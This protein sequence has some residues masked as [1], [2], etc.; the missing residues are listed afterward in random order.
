MMINKRLIG[1]VPD[2]KPYIAGNEMCI[3]DSLC[4]VLAFFQK[5]FFAQDIEI[6]KIGV[7]GEGRTALIGACLLYTSRCV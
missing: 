7:A 5:T 2:S 1:T 6:D 4:P 3:R